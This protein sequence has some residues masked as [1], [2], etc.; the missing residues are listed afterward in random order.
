MWLW[1]IANR[2]ALAAGV[3]FYLGAGMVTMLYEWWLHWH[4]QPRQEHAKWPLFWSLLWVVAT[5]PR[6]I[7]LRYERH[8]RGL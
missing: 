6:V 7:F 3:A 1:V 4:D 5:W 8:N 2:D